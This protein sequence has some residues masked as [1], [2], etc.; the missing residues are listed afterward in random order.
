MIKDELR[1]IGFRNFYKRRHQIK[2]KYQGL[3]SDEK[4]VY[5]Y[6]VYSRRYIKE[7]ACDVMWEF[8]NTDNIEE[9]QKL[10]ERLY[11]ETFRYTM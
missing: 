6:Y 8:L 11:D 2:E 4:Y 7:R 1:F 10:E 3:S 5:K 9:L